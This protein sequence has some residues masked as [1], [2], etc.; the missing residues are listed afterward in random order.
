MR[1]N[2]FCSWV[3]LLLFDFYRLILALLGFFGIDMCAFFYSLE[4]HMKIDAQ[5]LKKESERKK[6][7]EK[8]E[9]MN[10]RRTQ[11]SKLIKT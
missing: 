3:S 11:P 2:S 1:F 9:R 5:R 7:R 8:N 6:N 4:T 10:K